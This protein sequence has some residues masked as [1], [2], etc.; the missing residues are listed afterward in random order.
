MKSAATLTAD[1]RRRLQ[2]AWHTHLVG[3]EP[4]FPH[5]FPV[6]R[7][8]AAQLRTD[9]AGVL[10]ETVALQD[11]A[12]G[13]GA[14]LRYANRK[15]TG[16]THQTVPSH[17]QIESIDHAAAIAGE[18]WPQRLDR[19]RRRLQE[20][21][22]YHR[23]PLDLS[24]AVRLVDDYTDVD[25]ELL[26]T[27]ADWFR[28]DP[29]RA[30]LGI[31]PRQVPIPGVHA[32]WLQSHR[33]GVQGLTGLTD[34]GLLQRH[35]AR[36]HFTYLDPEHRA[37]GGRMHDSAT[38]GDS[39]KPAYAPRVVLISEN[40]DTAIHFPPISAGI[41]VEGVGRGGKTVAAF[42]W[43][44]Q[45]QHVVYWGDI[46]RDGFEILDGYRVDLDRDIDSMLMDE[47]TYERYAPFGTNLDQRGRSIAAGPARATPRLRP[48]EL[49]V[50][51]RLIDAGHQGHRRI[52]Q[53]RIPL[54][55]AVEAL[56]AIC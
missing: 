2:N 8:S 53:E 55:R 16:G 23:D 12:R 29:A 38:V 27:V 22:T 35:P 3:A 51:L 36:I 45:A 43:I 25:F 42:D 10:T 32:K 39:C 21:R 54:S 52:E 17:V 33:A 4:A 20:L 56:H 13:R 50:Y 7:P 11:W 28:E 30:D 24:R 46:D 14:T 41:S 1:I 5:A 44:R 40:K 6:G 18:P 37:A 47:A 15:A 9:Y 48:D 34:L 19:G 26:L 31:T 49:A